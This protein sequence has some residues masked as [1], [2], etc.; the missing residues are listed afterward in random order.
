MQK[1][2]TPKLSKFWAIYLSV[3]IVLIAALVVWL[4]QL[5]GMLVAYEASMPQHVAQAVCDA[6]TGGE[7]RQLYRQL[8][9][10]AQG[11][12]E[13]QFANYLSK[14]I[15]RRPVSY[16]AAHARDP[17]K[18]LFKLLAGEQVFA[19]LT[20]S[21]TE[22]ADRYGNRGWAV[23]GVSL[24]NAQKS[25]Y[26]LTVPDESVVLDGELK[27]GEE[28]IVEKDIPMDCD[29]HIPAK[30]VHVPTWTKYRVVRSFSQPTFRVLDRNGQQVPLTET[31]EGEF[32]CELS[33]DDAVKKA[34]GK[35]AVEIAKAYGMF[36]IGRMKKAN[37]MGYV[38]SGTAA[39]NMI[40]KY[41]ERW[42]VKNSGY[43]FENIKAEKFYPYSKNCYSCE[44]SYDLILKGSGGKS[45][46]Y[47]TKLTL[48]LYKSGGK[49]K[50]Y[51]LV[52]GQ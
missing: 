45:E 18:K 4:T 17:E 16:V 43:K 34:Q 3:V 21:A 40:Y 7:Y 44:V 2:P 14:Q 27:L 23:S 46:T 32:R 36:S 25:E 26:I 51:D 11:E 5:R 33:Y 8:D 37:F 41:D 47:P 6:L 13:A 49:F 1:R 30:K 9:A 50:L 28:Y 15:E 31:A 39:Y 52:I 22:E 35:R 24:P 20:L 10:A 38:L 12:T 29:G 19:Q 48:Y 42:F